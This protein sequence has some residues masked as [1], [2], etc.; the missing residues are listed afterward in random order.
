MRFG[1]V[2]SIS[3]RYRLNPIDL[4]CLVLSATPH[5]SMLVIDRILSTT[6]VWFCPKHLIDQW[7]LSIGFDPSITC[8]NQSDSFGYLSLLLVNV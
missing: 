6:Y 3:G 7:S 8:S 1:F 2:R 5:R 4:L